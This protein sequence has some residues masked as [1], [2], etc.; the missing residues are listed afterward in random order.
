MYQGIGILAELLVKIEAN[1]FKAHLVC[2]I[3]DLPAS[4]A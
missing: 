1:P 2:P 4:I 3:H